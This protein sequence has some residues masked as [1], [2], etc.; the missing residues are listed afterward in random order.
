M[1][2]PQQ[3]Y[4]D[5][6]VVKHNT[7]MQKYR[8]GLYICHQPII[9]TFGTFINFRLAK[10]LFLS[11]YMTVKY[12]VGMQKCV[13]IYVTDKNFRSGTRVEMLEQQRFCCV[14]SIILG[15]GY[16]I[17]YPQYPQ[18]FQKQD[19]NFKVQKREQLHVC[20][21]THVQQLCWFCIIFGC[22]KMVAIPYR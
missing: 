9:R 8:V 20:I 16:G 7:C 12:F 18:C 11:N 6:C 22:V 19:I 3:E 10:V 13:N 14:F 5:Q 21:Y 15:V 4:A 17:L 2:Q 1:E